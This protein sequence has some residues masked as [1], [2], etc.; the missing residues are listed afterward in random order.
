VYA[1]NTRSNRH[2]PQ[3]V[4]V[5]VRAGAWLVLYV[6]AILIMSWVGSF[7]GSNWIHAPWDSVVVGL[8]GVAGYVWGLAEA[9]RFLRARPAQNAAEEAGPLTE[10]V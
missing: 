8:I 3:Q 4:R 10:P 2:T 5:D 9:V 6:C 1:W 7:G